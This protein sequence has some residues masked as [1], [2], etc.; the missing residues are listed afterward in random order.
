M[1]LSRTA[2]LSVLALAM[3][4]C[5][6]AGEKSPALSTPSEKVLPKDILP[7]VGTSL[8]SPTRAVVHKVSVPSPSPN[9]LDCS[10]KEYPPFVTIIFPECPTNLK[11]G[12]ATLNIPPVPDELSWI[13]SQL[14][15]DI[16][17]D[18]PFYTRVIIGLDLTPFT[19]KPFA[20][21]GDSRTRV[22]RSDWSKY[23]EGP[24]DLTKPNKFSVTWNGAVIKEVE[25]NDQII[26]EPKEVIPTPT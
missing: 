13:K 24:I 14:G 4:A 23:I 22:A 26:D 2:A 18:H 3:A 6:P 8:D 9:V 7:K 21:V 1:E 17:I 11:V 25:W 16:T 12:R 10:P 5:T 19:I 20:Q 15:K